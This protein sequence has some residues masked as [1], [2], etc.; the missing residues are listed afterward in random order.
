MERE[1]DDTKGL[2]LRGKCTTRGGRGWILEIWWGA[3][4][5]GGTEMVGRDGGSEN[6]RG[7]KEEN[8]DGFRR[9]NGEGKN[10]EERGRKVG[11]G[12]RR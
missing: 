3:T 6:R 2:K 7:G 5:K 10:R 12:T 11:E 1:K 4:G 8:G 9:E